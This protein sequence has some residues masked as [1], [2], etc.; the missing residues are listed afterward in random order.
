[1][2][3]TSYFPGF[4]YTHLSFPPSPHPMCKFYIIYHLCG[5]V[6]LPLQLRYWTVSPAQGALMLIFYNDI[7][8]Q[9]YSFK[10]A[11]NSNM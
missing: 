4:I 9:H 7:H 3:F 10:N 1:M 6:N 8:T 5:F 2:Y 11:I